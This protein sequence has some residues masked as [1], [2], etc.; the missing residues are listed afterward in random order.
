[1]IKKIWCLA[2]AA[3]LLCGSTMP[4]YAE[5]YKGEGDWKV[6]FTGKGMESNFKGKDITNAIYDLQPGDSVTL[7]ID[8]SNKDQKSADWYMTNEILSSLE[9]SQSVAEGGAYTYDL[10]YTNASGT[11]KTLFSSSSIGGE[12]GVGLTEAVESMGDYVYLDRL[13]AGGSGTVR[14]VVSLDGETQGNTYQDTLANLRMNFAV[15]KANA[16]TVS[17]DAGQQPGSGAYTA[18]NVRTGDENNIMIWTALALASGLLLLLLAFS[19]S[20]KEGNDHE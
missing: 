13:G 9:D 10:S 18:G 11:V 7:Q 8:L 19:R 20:R 12:K 14:M 17:S 4:V 16:P 3:I 15:E 2:M 1:M 5:D 6:E